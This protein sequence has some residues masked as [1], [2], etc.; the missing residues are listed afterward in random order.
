MEESS[1]GGRVATGLCAVKSRIKGKAEKT[2]SETQEKLYWQKQKD[3][4]T[5]HEKE[6]H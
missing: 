2:H 6:Q 4:S 5:C 3:K 1:R